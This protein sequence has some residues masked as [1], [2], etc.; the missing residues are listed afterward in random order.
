[1]LI[2][3]ALTLMVPMSLVETSAPCAWVKLP[4]AVMVT[5]PLVELTFPLMTMLSVLLV[6]LVMVMLPVA[7]IPLE[8]I[9]RFGVT[10]LKRISPLLAIAV[11]WEAVLASGRL[12]ESA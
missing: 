2:L 5:P 3:V 1:M 8:R 4:P 11:N 6:L 7:L 12:M 10:V 9:S